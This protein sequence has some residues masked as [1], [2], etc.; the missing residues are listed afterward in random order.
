MKR[1]FPFPIPNGWFQVSYSDELEP[2][3]V[4]PIHY[5]G[6]DLV[7]FRDRSGAARVFDAYCVHLGAHLGYGGVVVGD[8]IQCP[9]HGWRYDGTGRCV[10]IPYARKIPPRARLRVWP[11]CEKNG[12][13]LVWR[14]A[15][16]EPP[17]WEIPDV[18][19]YASDDWTPYE[20]REWI[21]RT[22]NQEMAEN[23][24]D[25]AHFYFVH[26]TQTIADTEIET[27]GP[28][29]RV[30]S[31]SKMGTPRG[32]AD[33]RIE[34]ETHGFG[35]GVTRFKGI[36][37]TLLVTSGA[38]IDDEHV[39]MRLSFSVRK[40]PNSDATRGVGQAFI[41]EVE[42]QFGQDIPIWENKIHHERP[43]LCDGD[44]PFAELRRWARQFYS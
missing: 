20:R 22:R 11:V 12:L 28:V 1:Q 17:T 26:G 8:A 9:F 31:S 29:L 44:G 2:G 33:G 39:H 36:V 41:A 24:V 21:I 4:K 37:E 18:P 35:F 7:L 19:E 25:Q 3:E 10:E 5:F 34:I 13:V 43:M 23:V 16:G 30:V 40:L 14:H 32:E 42:R 6:E 27:D 38:P 15:T